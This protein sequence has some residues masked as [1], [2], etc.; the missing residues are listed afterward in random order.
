MIQK[1]IFSVC[2]ILASLTGLG[3]A[4]AEQQDQAPRPNIILIVADDLGY[5]DLSLTGSDLIDTPHIDRMAADGIQL[6]DFHTS[7]N[8]CTPSRAGL[9]T[10]RYP[11]RSGLALGVVQPWH[12]HGLSQ[13]EYTLAEL[14]K[15]AGYATAMIGKWH[16]GHGQEHWPTRHGF[17]SFYGVLYSNDMNPFALYRGTENI[18]EP[19]DQTTLTQRYTQETIRFMEANKDRPFF[20]YLPHTFPHIPLYASEEFSGTSE[21]GLYG[22]VVETLD[23]STGEII[24]ALKRLGLDRNT[25]VIFTS[26]NGP[27]FEGSSARLRGRKGGVY[28]GGYQVPFIARWPGAIP[29]GTESPALTTNLDLM[30]TIAKL[31]GADLP[32]GVAIDG[33]DIMPVL[34][35]SQ[36]SPHDVVYFFDN[37]RI[38]AV[39]SGKW[40]Y[41]VSTFY[42]NF[43]IPLEGFAGPMLFDLEK[44]PSETVSY[45]RDNHDVVRRMQTYLAA[46]RKDLEPLAIDPSTLKAPPADLQQRLMRQIQ[47]GEPLH[48]G[49]NT[50]PK[51]AAPGP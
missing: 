33:K 2:L 6:T 51:P 25:L 11:I 29:P 37:Q 1:L 4:R 43:P 30:P 32:E 42:R 31:A 24:A 34:S 26:D 14:L 13:S 10:G 15:D 47:L 38:A 12:D 18:E 20:I 8:V 39:R 48:A 27:W 28:N 22:D 46:G 5:G 36:D 41:V 7:A 16:L 50:P 21:G 19:V 49:Q 45:I 23:W 44:D 35:G 9:L 17:D 3:M 40:K